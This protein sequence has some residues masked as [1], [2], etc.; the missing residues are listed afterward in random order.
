[1]AQQRDEAEAFARAMELGV[2]VVAEI[3]T[4]SD[5][6]LL[7]EASPSVVLCEISLSAGRYP[8]NVMGLLRQL[9][10]VPNRTVVNYLLVALLNQKLKSDPDSRQAVARALFLMA[11]GDDIADARL[12]Q[13]TYRVDD[14]LDLVDAGIIRKSHEEIFAEMAAALEAAAAAIPPTMTD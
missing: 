7:K 4:W 3:T 8:E 11:I 6:L 13:T 2:S 14:D 1:M 12:L 10:G 9:P 5:D